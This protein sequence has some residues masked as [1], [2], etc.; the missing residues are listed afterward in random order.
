MV[1][2]ETNAEAPSGWTALEE[3]RRPYSAAGGVLKLIGA[4]LLFTEILKQVVHV[5]YLTKSLG[6]KSPIPQIR[7]VKSK[8]EA[9]I[10]TPNPRG[11]AESYCI[12]WFNSGSSDSRLY[13]LS[14]MLPP[15]TF[16]Q[17]LILQ[18]VSE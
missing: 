4:E 12:I 16:L 2:V 5:E 6:G 14:I 11:C 7:S 10:T 9:N 13:A 18:R 17:T 1:K 3:H 15:R 8:L